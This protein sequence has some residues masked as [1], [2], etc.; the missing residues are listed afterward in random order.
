[1]AVGG[2]IVKRNEP[3]LVLCVDVR[4]VLQEVFSHIQIIIAGRQVEWSRIPPLRVTAINVAAR[5]EF[6]DAGQM[7]LLGSVQQCRVT[8]KKVSN[9]LIPVTNQIQ[10]GVAVSVLLRWIGPVL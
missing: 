1:M 6:V 5:D 9:V 8:A 3:A 7:A 2:S 10:R 4:P